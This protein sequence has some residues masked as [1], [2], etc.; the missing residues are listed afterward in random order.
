MTT[1]ITFTDAALEAM[2]ARRAHRADPI[3]LADAL[4]AAI[5]ATEPRRGPRLAWPASWLPGRPSRG[6]AMVLVAATLLLALLGSALAGASFLRPQP[7]LSLVPNAIET[8]TPKRVPYDRVVE[9]GAGTLWAIGTGHL[10][11]F[12]P[13]TGTRQTWTVSDD[14]AFAS[15]IVAPARAGGV[16][17]WSGTS[18][19]RFTGDRFRESIPVTAADQPTELVETPGGSLWA[20][21]W[22]RGL[23]R[24][25][26][27]RWV[28]EPA[29]RRWRPA[30]SC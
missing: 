24:W 16:W 27:S 25:D 5:E 17:I 13:G 29:G 23:E 1:Q 18:I 14:Y 11:R 20:A 3:G 2:L 12:D 26:G 9:D 15:S 8:L 10:T 7:P 21:S 19:R 28:A 30:P 4:F 22:D 6:L